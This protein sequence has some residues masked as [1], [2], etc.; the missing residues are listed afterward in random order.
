M[1]FAGKVAIVTGAGTG[2]GREVALRLLREGAL[3]VLVGRR[4]DKLD[5]VIAASGSSRNAA[6]LPTDISKLGQARALVQS[7]VDRFGRIDILVNNAAV[8]YGGG[9]GDVRP[10]EVE[11]LMKVDV[12]AQIWLTQLV[13]PVMRRRRQALIVNVSSLA[14]LVPIPNQSFYCAAKH[15]LHGF[16]H[17]LRRELLGTSID[18]L[19]VYPGLFDMM[20]ADVAAGIIV[21]GMK[22]RRSSILVTNAPERQLVRLNRYFPG[23]VDRRMKK[24]GPKIRNVVTAATQSARARSPLLTSD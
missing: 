7:V 24:L 17:S 9:I 11:Y 23:L 12:V 6:A 8:G 16:S 22:K 13:V 1:D 2:V 14:G 15:G 10:E 19:T 3:V 5:E 18:V 21:D 4:R 20:K